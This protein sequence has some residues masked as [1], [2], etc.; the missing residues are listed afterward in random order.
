MNGK[1]MNISA[2]HYSS[3][4]SAMTTETCSDEIEA[5]LVSIRGQIDATLAAPLFTV[6]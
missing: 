5:D 2:I 1:R 6:N 3:L 4:S